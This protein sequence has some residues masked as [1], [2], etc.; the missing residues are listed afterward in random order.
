MLT[1]A[2]K[3]WV[4]ACPSCLLSLN[5]HIPAG[6]GQSSAEAFPCDRL[7]VVTEEVLE[8]EGEQVELRT[9]RHDQG[10]VLRSRDRRQGVNWKVPNPTQGT[11]G[12][13]NGVMGGR[14]VNGVGN[15][16]S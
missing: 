1:N 8:E 5:V 7:V 15:G 4:E 13:G 6:P 2:H 11:R 3:R 10:P 14:V 12:G 16:H 9:S